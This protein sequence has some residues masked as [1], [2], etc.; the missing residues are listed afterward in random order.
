MGDRGCFRSV[1]HR[2]FIGNRHGMPVNT[3]INDSIEERMNRFTVGR[4]G[5]CLDCSV[6]SSVF[7][8]F[9][10]QVNEHLVGILNKG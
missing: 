3:A 10:Q 7:S 6:L 4:C 5:A 8:Q 1:L 9:A 2:Y